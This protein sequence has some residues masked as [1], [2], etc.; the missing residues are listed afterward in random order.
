[1]PKTTLMTPERVRRTVTRLAYEVIE[2]NRGAEGL[3]VFG[4]KTRGAAL[5]GRLA[6]AL[7]EASGQS[8]ERHA[9]SIS[10]FRDDRDGAIAPPNPDAPDAE[11]RDVLLVDDVLF[12]G[13]TAR[14]ALDAV[15]Q[16][17]RP[18]TIRLAVLVDRGHREVPVHPDFVGRVVPT[19]HAER[20][21]VD[22]D[23]PAVY[24][25]E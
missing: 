25:E 5:A 9:L 22:P 3:L 6:D 8:V 17:G 19:K 23:V 2:R 10:G 21:V 16:Y 11:G 13:R 18:R 1:M 15:L 14:A 4:L 20:V 24:L 7:E 12:T